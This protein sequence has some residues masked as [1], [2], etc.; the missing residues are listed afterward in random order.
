M[1]QDSSQHLYQVLRRLFPANLLPLFHHVYDFAYS[2]GGSLEVDFLRLEGTSYNPR[3]ARIALIMLK[4]ASVCDPVAI[5]A[6]ILITIQAPLKCPP[7]LDLAL[8]FADHLED[9]KV[10]AHKA[11]SYADNITPHSNQIFAKDISAQDKL[12]I[13][14]AL[15][16]WLDRF[17]H[18]HQATPSHVSSHKREILNAA[19]SCKLIAE[20]LDSPLAPIIR[21]TARKLLTKYS[22]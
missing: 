13:L 20:R 3:P 21:E 8:D 9:A 15:S 2:N 1:I 12:T 5:A 16:L 10:L 4:E 6:S 17:R 22:E 11:T 18:F 19:N 14:I 7:S